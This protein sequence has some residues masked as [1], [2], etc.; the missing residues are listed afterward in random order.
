MVLLKYLMKVSLI[1]T[2]LVAVLFLLFLLPQVIVPAQPGQRSPNDEELKEA[3]RL[4]ESVAELFKQGKYDEALPP[5]KRALKIQQRLLGPTNERVAVSLN[6]LAEILLAKK[7]NDEAETL[8]GEALAI[9]EKTE[10]RNA[11]LIENVLDRLATIRFLKKDYS[12]AAALLERSLALGGKTSGSDNKRTA[13]TMFELAVIYQW[14]AHYEKAEPLFL[15]SLKLKE[16]LL[17]ASDP[18][19]IKAMKVFACANLHSFQTAKD[20]RVADEPFDE[21]KAVI[22]RAYCWLGEFDEKCADTPSDQYGGRQGFLNGK[23]VRLPKPD[24]PAIA[25]AQRLTGTVFISV[26]V[27]EKGDVIKA[28]GVC[29]GNPV[30]TSGSLVSARDAKFTATTLNGQPIPVT[31]IITYRFIRQ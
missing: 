11:E 2:T 12:K 26:L 31:G 7:N 4:Q 13:E 27:N 28:R 24:Y 14:Q 17:G 19:T 20:L 3:Q 23:A 21:N 22:T 10:A 6:N 9:F 16:K 30:L 1:P 8:F 15:Q 29:G 25:R 18:N 5:A